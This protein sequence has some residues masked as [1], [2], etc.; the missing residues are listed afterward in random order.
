L[1]RIVCD[2]TSL[3]RK[4]LLESLSL[5]KL[6]V[7]LYCK[8]N[9][10]RVQVATWSDL[11]LGGSQMGLYIEVDETPMLKESMETNDAAYISS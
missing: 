1:A 11:H 10:V 7:A 5:I 2:F 6:N 3:F 8:V 4:L 9:Q